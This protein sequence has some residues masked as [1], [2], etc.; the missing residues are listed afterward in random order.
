M[1]EHLD[2]DLGEAGDAGGFFGGKLLGE[3]Q[4]QLGMMVCAAFFFA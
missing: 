1:D 3:P 4:P 2:V